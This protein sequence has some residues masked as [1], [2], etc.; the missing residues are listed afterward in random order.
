MSARPGPPGSRTRS[1][2]GAVGWMWIGPVVTATRIRAPYACGDGAQEP[3]VRCRGRP[4]RRSRPDRP[5]HDGP[6]LAGARRAARDARRPR[7]PAR[8]DRQAREA[9]RDA[10]A[11]GQ[12]AEWLLMAG[13]EDPGEFRTIMD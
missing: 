9:R 12:A 10:R 7:D 2:S 1:A 11:E 8:A 4:S 5:G 13:V 6:G 3:R